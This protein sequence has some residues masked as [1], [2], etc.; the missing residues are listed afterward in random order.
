[1]SVIAFSNESCAI[2]DDF[3]KSVAERLAYDYIGRE[4]FELASKKWDVPESKL[5]EAIHMGPSFLGMSD[6]V[7]KRYLAYFLASAAECFVRDDLVYNNLACHIVAKRIAHV[8]KVRISAP[9]EMRIEFIMQRD[10][11]T[12]EKA[13]QVVISEEK[14]R[15]KWSCCVFGEDES[16]PK[17]YDLFIDLN[18]MDQD[19]AIECI[20]ETVRDPKFQP[21]T[22]SRQCA[23]NVELSYRLRAL[24]IDLDP[25]I[26]I[27]CRDGSVEIQTKAYG[28]AKQKNIDVIHQRLDTIEDI[29]QLDIKMR[30]DLFQNYEGIMR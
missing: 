5:T 29:Q 11:L 22:Y 16:N 9:Q 19:R 14:N 26:Q 12:R 6:A 10:S 24:L 17:F 4:V 8:V 18:H 28:S 13:E 21:T 25:E 2:R 20:V 15:E 7:R 27:H 1:M 3:A 23:K 30:D